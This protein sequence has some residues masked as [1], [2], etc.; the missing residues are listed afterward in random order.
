M[1]AKR[2]NLNILTQEEHVLSDEVDLVLAPASQGQIGILPGHA[3]LLTQLSA[4]ELFILKGPKMEVFA[5]PGGFLDIHRDQLTVM[6][7]SATRA[8]DLSLAAAEAAKK[9]AE[10]TLKQNLS[11]REFSLAEADLRKAVLELKV[12]KK[13]RKVYTG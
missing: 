4:G 1:A 3:S 13:R 7:D 8:D 11:D 5:V 6:A 2:L 9:R 10:E 12:A